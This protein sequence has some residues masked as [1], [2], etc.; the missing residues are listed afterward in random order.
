MVAKHGMD[1]ALILRHS[2][3]PTGSNFRER[4]P[5]QAASSAPKINN[6]TMR[7]MTGGFPEGAALPLL[8]HE[9]TIS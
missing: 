3:N 5:E 2:A 7:I 1:D 4:Q 9:R 6:A 8:K